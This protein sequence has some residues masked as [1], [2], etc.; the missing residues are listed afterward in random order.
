MDTILQK[1]V[2]ASQLVSLLI[3]PQINLSEIQP[4][5]IPN[6]PII[7]KQDTEINK[8]IKRLA[9]CESGNNNL[10]INKTDKNGKS[11][12]GQWQFQDLSWK[13]YIKKY[14]L[15]NWR[16][17]DEADYENAIWD[18]QYQKVV[19]EKMFIDPDINLKKEF[20]EC[21]IKLKLKK[22]YPPK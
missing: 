11:S 4:L 22:N 16:E 3:I 12:K 8:L 19:V 1:L 10:A 21:A 20:P 17:W 13:H 2:S 15:W 6:E 18:A 14:D 7:Q 5:T 9:F